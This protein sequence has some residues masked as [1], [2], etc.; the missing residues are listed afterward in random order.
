MKVAQIQSRIRKLQELERS[1]P[2][3]AAAG[4]EEL[5]SETLAAIADG[6]DDPRR[7]ATEVMRTVAEGVGD[8]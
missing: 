1:D 4:A 7:L 8:R 2:E 6:A 3:A 5:R